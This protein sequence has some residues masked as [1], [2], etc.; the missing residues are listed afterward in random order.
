MTL[1]WG[2]VAAGGGAGQWF[3]DELERVYVLR[4]ARAVAAATEG[5]KAIEKHVNKAAIKQAKE[6]AAP[7]HLRGRVA[8]G[9]ALPGLELVPK[10]ELKRMTSGT[11][12]VERERRAVLQHVVCGLKIDLFLDLM[13]GLRC[14]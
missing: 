4:K 9:G 5:V 13:A 6:Q 2:G 1:V 8:K 7:A 3:E 14:R 11:R 10:S 12:R